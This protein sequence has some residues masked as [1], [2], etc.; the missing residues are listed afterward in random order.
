M[1]DK[2]ASSAAQGL[3][4]LSIDKS[5]RPVAS[6]RSWLGLPIV[7]L[8]VGSIGGGAGL[9]YYNTTGVNIIASVAE[10][11]VAV[12][13]YE[14]PKVDTLRRGS[15]ALVANGKIVSDVL[16]NVATK[17]SGQII[18]LHVEQ[19]DF[20]EK[21]KVL[22]RIEDDVYRAQRDEAQAAVDRLIRTIEQTETEL[23]RQLAAAEEAR[24]MHGWREYNFNRLK[25]L[26]EQ[27]LANE[28]EVVESRYLYEAAS[29]ALTVANEAAE[30]TERSIKVIQADLEAAKSRLR[31]WQKRLDDC[32]IRAPISGIVLERNAQVGDF[33]AAEGGRGANANAQL[34]S[35]ADMT[36]LRVEIDVSERDIHRI[37]RD[38]KARI[39][40][41]ANKS[42]SFTG[43]VMWVDPIGDYA[44]AVVQT[45]VRINDP[46]PELRVEGS[47]KVEFLSPEGASADDE[48]KKSY[49]LPLDAVKIP[50]S[51][52]DPVVFTVIDGRAAANTIKIGARSSKTIEVTSGVHPGLK[53][54]D[55]N[56]DEVKDGALVDVD[57]IN[58]D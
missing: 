47:A 5:Q 41:D 22:A 3:E 44:R 9:W 43:Y 1:D 4:R 15:I 30:S 2:T 23:R 58:Q 38:Q 18:S 46:T 29:A 56:L 54:I 37:F 52:G 26:D 24:A 49:W 16:V 25:R 57:A 21:D 36:L 40:P 8:A 35:I 27:D 34:V 45:K 20:V 55:G 31:L 48:T 12:Q 42:E 32:A 39:T 19:G 6:R 13:L 7:I 17:V 51:D 50:T 28:V 53:I 10:R 33:L 11:P 14:I